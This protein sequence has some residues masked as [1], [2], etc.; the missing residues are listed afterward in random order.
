MGAGS[1]GFTTSVLILMSTSKIPL[2]IAVLLLLAGAVG[3]GVQ[4]HARVPIAA[5]I[6][7]RHPI[8]KADFSPQRRGAPGTIACNSASSRTLTA[9]ARA[10]ADTLKHEL[11]QMNPAPLAKGMVPMSAWKNVGR[12]SPGNALETLLW[13]AAGGDYKKLAAMIALG[14]TVKSQADTL[15]SKMPEDM[16]AQFAGVTT[17]EEMVALAYSTVATEMAGAQMV[18]S[19]TQRCGAM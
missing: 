1:V 6:S 18:Q 16:K 10:G 4:A 19:A 12:K 14:P 5:R 2:V 17:P 13:T 9:P 8:T 15:F 7:R 3:I 11:A